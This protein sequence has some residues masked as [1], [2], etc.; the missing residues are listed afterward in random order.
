MAR[1]FVLGDA[2]P[3]LTLNEPDQFGKTRLAL[4]SRNAQITRSRTRHDRACI[5]TIHRVLNT[6]R[7]GIYGMKAAH[8]WCNENAV[9]GVEMARISNGRQ[10]HE[11][12]CVMASTPQRQDSNWSTVG[13]ADFGDSEWSDNGRSEISGTV[14]GSG[15]GGTAQMAKVLGWFSLG[16]GLT[17][18]AAPRQVANMIGL[19]GDDNEQT[20]MRLIGLREIVSGVGILAQAKPTPWLWSRVG[21]DAMDLALLRS[22]MDVPEA[23]KD[24]VTA[25]TIAV[26]GITAADLFCST[27]V[28]TEPNG[29]TEA[30][31]SKDDQVTAAAA[32]A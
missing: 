8:F 3:L 23:R 14:A 28:I 5:R 24:R 27:K 26:M 1:S 22:A 30:L 13:Q 29:S 6:T 12:R 32:R 19:P 15:A 7:T 16:L 20:I 18:L 31:A 2:V 9:V 10:R 25:A 11:R 4:V 17:Q 21:G